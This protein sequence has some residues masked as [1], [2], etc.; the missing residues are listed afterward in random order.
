[1]A[2]TNQL[3]I[4][5]ANRPG[6]VAEVARVLADAKVNLLACVGVAHG[7]GGTVHVVVDSAARARK[8]LNA[9]NIAYT[10]SAAEQYELSNK[11]GAL[12]DCLEKL[13]AKGV[14]LTSIYA[15]ASKT[16]KKVVVV[17]SSAAA[18]GVQSKGAAA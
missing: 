13:A 18:A 5:I 1:M 7:D 11:P 12:A 8:A 3:T 9:A 17:V 10:E 16:A 4:S 2:K 6:T 15:T 14:N